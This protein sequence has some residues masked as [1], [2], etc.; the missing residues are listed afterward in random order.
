VQGTCGFDTGCRGAHLLVRLILNDR[1][2]PSFV[3]VCTTPGAAGLALREFNDAHRGGGERAS[4]RFHSAPLPSL[5]CWLC[6]PGLRWQSRGG[7]AA[8]LTG[9]CVNGKHTLGVGPAAAA[10]AGGGGA[11][12]G[13]A[14]ALP[15]RADAHSAAQVHGLLIARNN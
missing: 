5:Q 3:A 1:V 13:P 8:Y 6:T 4:E 15:V 2:S 10:L 9:V 14:P 7:Y 12:A 11:G